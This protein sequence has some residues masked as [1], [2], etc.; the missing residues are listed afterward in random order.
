MVIM[1]ENLSFC[2]QETSEAI[3]QATVLRSHLIT[4]TSKRLLR[5]CSM[6]NCS[7]VSLPSHLLELDFLPPPPHPT[8]LHGRKNLR[9]SSTA[10][11]FLSAC[12]EDPL[13]EDVVD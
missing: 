3:Q 11:P 12:P 10:C 4:R 1:N 6:K 8:C 2:R 7:P 13:L 9:I 5:G